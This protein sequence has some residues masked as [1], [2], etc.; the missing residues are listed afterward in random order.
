MNKKETKEGK[1]QRIK[2]SVGL[3]CIVKSIYNF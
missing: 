3:V 1:K 2:G